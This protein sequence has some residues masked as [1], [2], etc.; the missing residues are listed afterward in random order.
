MKNEQTYKKGDK[1]WVLIP[2]ESNQSQKRLAI[3][4]S[5]VSLPAYMNHECHIAIRYL[6]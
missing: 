6:D 3:I 5:V 4:L 1:V 2:I